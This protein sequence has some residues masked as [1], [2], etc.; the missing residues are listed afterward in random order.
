MNNTQIPLNDLEPFIAMLDQFKRKD[1]AKEVLNVFGKHSAYYDQYDNLAK[2]F[3]K[4]KMYEDSIVY[5]EKTVA[6]SGSSQQQFT[7]RFNLINVYNHANYPE[8]AMRYINQCLTIDPNNIDVILEKAYSLFLLNKKS[9][10]EEILQNTLDN[11][12][13]LSDEYKTKIRF[14]LGTYYLYKDKFQEGLKLFLEEGVKMRF[15]NTE[16]IFSRNN[17]IFSE[18]KNLHYET[19]NQKIRAEKFIKWDGKVKPNMPIIIHAEAGIGDEIINFRF[20]EKIRNMGMIPYWYNSYNERKDLLDVFKRHGYNVITS[21]EEVKGDKIYYAQSMHLPI[22]MN[23]QYKDLWNGP[24]L[25]AKNESIEKWKFLEKDKP[26]IGIRWQGNPAYDHDLH[27]S[28][29]LQQLL[30]IFS[31]K[32]V[33]LYSLQKDNGLEEIDSKIIDLSDKLETW[34]DTLGCIHNLDFVITSCTSVAHACAAMD[35]KTYILLPISA[36][37]VWSHSSEKSPWY[38]ENVTLLR[39]Q[40]PRV[41]DEPIEELK[42]LLSDF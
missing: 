21:I 33:D 11:C 36:Y 30:K 35:K 5:A 41:W 22:I 10:A 24:Y 14:N 28:F 3:F 23:L 29:P 20:M 26:A 39:Q 37:Y 6:V 16:S 38:G 12:A 2:C 8:K 7:S 27:R 18:N 19:M 40:K 15:W 31:G 25:K 17:N 4:L 13:E 32:S 1:L 9:Q 42:N 34:D